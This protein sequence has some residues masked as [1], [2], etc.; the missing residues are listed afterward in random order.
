MVTPLVAPLPLDEETSE[1]VQKYSSEKELGKAATPWPTGEGLPQAASTLTAA[2]QAVRETF[3][4]TNRTLRDNLSRFSSGVVTRATK[5]IATRVAE[6]P[7]TR[8]VTTFEPHLRRSMLQTISR[9]LL[10]FRESIG[11]PE[12]A[13]LVAEIQSNLRDSYKRSV[14]SPDTRNL[15]SAISLLQDFLRPHWSQLS[16][17][18]L[19]AVNEA[20]LRLVT[21]IDLT[22]RL[23]EKFYSDLA[24][25]LN[26]RISFECEEDDDTDSVS[27]RD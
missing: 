22:P 2:A 21:H 11:E 1:Y 7:R 15:A 18:Q 17:A 9:L 14:L 3:V 19:D 24:L 13:V 16:A 10:R 12:S 25:A 8:L 4:P 27:G 20:L 5:R 23:L 26:S 6:L